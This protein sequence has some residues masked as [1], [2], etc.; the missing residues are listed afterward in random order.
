M[1]KI[2]FSILIFL[3]GCYQQTE[4]NLILT[5][6][7]VITLNRKNPQAQIVVIKNDKIHHVGSMADLDNYIE[8]STKIIDL[9][10]KT[11][12]PGFIDAHAHFM[13]LGNSLINI[14]LNQ[15][16]N[17]DEA[18]KKV[19]SSL[20]DSQMGDWITGRGWHQEKWEKSP[21]QNVD[22]YP[23]HNSISSFSPDNP[24]L[25]KH[26]SGH[27][28]FVN[29]KA[30]EIAGIDSKTKDPDGG[31]IIR[32]ADGNPTG[33]LLETA[34]DLVYDRYKEYQESLSL[35]EQNR[36][37][38][39]YIKAATEHCLENGVTTFHDAGVWFKEIDLFK[40]L[41]KKDALDIRL[42]VMI[43]SEESLSHK[44]LKKYK[45]IGFGNDHLTVRAI[46]QYADGALGS[47]G[48]WMLEP[49][50]DMPSTSGLNVT[51]LDSIK[52]TAQLAFKNGYQLCTHAI[53]DRG[54]RE[55]LDIYQ[56]TLNGDL[57]RRWRIEHA[58]H[59]S[60]DD[61]TRFD[62]MGIIASMQTVHCTSDG[63][64]VPVRIG[65]K[66]SEQGAYVWQK[67]LQSGAY[68]ANGTDSPVERLSPIANYYAA[69]TR[70]LNDGSQFYPKQVLSRKDALKSLTIWNAFAGFE[71]NIKGSIEV[72][73]LADLVV[74]SQN[75]LTV[76][77]DEILNTKVLYTIVGGN[78]KYETKDK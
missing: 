47:R 62:S 74:L 32:D 63:P 19:E 43:S 9:Q 2:L 69:V 17:W 1:K 4:I 72:G 8:P 78:V 5:N 15:I 54:N 21:K 40:K 59:L 45:M 28:I 34:M 14:D 75:I 6:A 53:G 49:Y 25:L 73:K 71:E 18:V 55:M 20:K 46:K 58:Q 3:T 16:T 52:R 23:V 29:A 33:V 22:G 30:M 36:I 66:R 68:I 64:W 77:K 10:G 67:I 70:R 35:E 60:L 50:T 61:I 44:L 11:V 76:P 51:P 42:W 26:A 39:E 27:A 7:N 31:E 13:S 56:N 48:A 57:F 41:A 65:D 38:L 24:V 12:I 37:N